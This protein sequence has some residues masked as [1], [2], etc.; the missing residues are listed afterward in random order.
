MAIIQPFFA[1]VPDNSLPLFSSFMNGFMQEREKMN[2]FAM[3][4]FLEKQSPEFLD[5]HIKQTNERI[6][7]LEKINADLTMKGMEEANKLNMALLKRYKIRSSGYRTGVSAATR[8]KETNKIK[9]ALLTQKQ[10]FNKNIE[11]LT[12]R[13]NEIV[14]GF[15]DKHGDKVIEAVHGLKPTRTDV[16]SLSADP[17]KW[18]QGDIVQKIIIPIVDDIQG[19]SGSYE[20]ASPILKQQMATVV[21]EGYYTTMGKRST[22]NKTENDAIQMFSE[23][24]G[25]Y[26]NEQKE[27][28]FHD[29]VRG[30]IGEPK[31]NDWKTGSANSADG[32]F[33]ENVLKKK[34]AEFVKKYRQKRQGITQLNY[35]DHEKLK[36]DILSGMPD[37]GKLVSIKMDLE[38]IENSPDFVAAIKKM[39]KGEALSPSEK[40]K[41][42]LHRKT[43]ANYTD[44]S[45]VVL[46]RFVPAGKK[47][48]FKV[49]HADFIKAMGTLDPGLASAFLGEKLPEGA[50]PAAT[51]PIQDQLKRL[52]NELK[53]LRMRRELIYEDSLKG[54]ERFFS[55]FKSNYLLETPFKRPGR[56]ET[57]ALKSLENER[58]RM[59]TPRGNKS[60]IYPN[61][62]VGNPYMIDT[63]LYLGV[64]NQNMPFVQSSFN[65]PPKVVDANDPD[66]DYL[67]TQLKIL[68]KRIT[69]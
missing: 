69:L 19:Y 9:K 44:V 49:N 32:K 2:N 1:P 22:Q 10:N 21:L 27:A 62:E 61:L 15:S 57:L 16:E 60:Q 55:G 56:R 3:R 35:A 59:T 17:S 11:N 42:T 13:T 50:I 5:A 54:A 45:E 14:N 67:N 46:R 34:T 38:R 30:M 36:S 28:A 39:R 47:G 4:A 37:H 25:E 12:T 43:K 52:R 41:L 23:T 26:G 48:K 58:R 24:S 18:T 40:N 68:N 63:G 31:F 65:A 8:Y 66:F 51:K 20:K 53:G 6:I 7:E 33:G 64:N 29:I